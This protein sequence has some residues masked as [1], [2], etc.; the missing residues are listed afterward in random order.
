MDTA[1]PRS[2]E[3]NSPRGRESPVHGPSGVSGTD[4]ALDALALIEARRR[5]DD[6][7]AAFLLDHADLRAVCSV[8]A[9]LLAVYLG[10]DD[11]ESVRAILAELARLR[12]AL[13]ADGT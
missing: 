7:A 5:D 11:P 4:A 3:S 10:D 12:P 1:G 2:P 6:A 8:L 13:V 9:G